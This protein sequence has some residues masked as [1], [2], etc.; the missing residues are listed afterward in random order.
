MTEHPIPVAIMDGDCA[1]C[2]FGARA[3]DWLDQS[4][5]IR[6]CP[7]Q[8]PLGQ[9][10]LAENGLDPTDPSTWLF[11]DET[12]VY[13]D[14]DAMIRVGARSGGIGH[15]LRLLLLLPRPARRWLYHRIA[16]NRYRW[17]GRR[18]MCAFPKASL[19]ARIIS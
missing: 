18:D 11:L 4:G 5:D 1:L 16:R 8:T 15:V 9:A 6:I 12:G 2:T 17:F 19:Q 14:F 13:R 3:I 7:I 10:I